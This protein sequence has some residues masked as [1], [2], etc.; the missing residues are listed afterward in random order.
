[1]N[2]IILLAAG[3][4]E[5]LMTLALKYAQ[6]WTRPWPSGLGIAAA[7]LSIFLLT[8]ALRELPVGTAYAIWTGIGA[9]GIAV[10]G[11]VLFGESAAP[12]RLLCIGVIVCGIVGLRVIE[13]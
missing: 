5:I 9:V 11:I 2:W 10:L 3:A 12:L 4:V 8:Y 1:M 7:L 6:G 13:N